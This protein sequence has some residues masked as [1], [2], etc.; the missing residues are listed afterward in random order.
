[1]KVPGAHL[2]RSPTCPDTS[3]F[4]QD[5][6]LFARP[7]DDERLEFSEEPARV[8]EGVPVMGLGG[9]PSRCP[10]RAVLAYWPYPVGHAGGAAL[11]RSKRPARPPPWTAPALYSGFTLS[12]D[13]GTGGVFPAPATSGGADV[14]IRDL[15]NG[16]EDR[17]TFDGA[18]FTPQ[19]SSRRGAHRVQRSGRRRP[20]IK[21]FIKNV[22]IEGAATGSASRPARTLRRAGAE[23]AGRSSASAIDPVNRFDLWTHR[24]QDQVDERLSLDTRFNEVAR[25]GLSERVVGS[26]TIPTHRGGAK[27]GWRAFPSGEN[28]ASGVDRRGCLTGMG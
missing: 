25:P 15:G 18:A 23:T 7:F 20:P 1:M 27:C 2:V 26:P 6:A 10:R 24:L 4:V 28:P 3:L 14:W 9:R 17:Q 19:W 21:L 22:G 13:A 16:K 5:A 8:V 12:P 11:V